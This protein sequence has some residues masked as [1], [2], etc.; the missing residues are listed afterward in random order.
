MSAASIV[1]ATFASV[2]LAEIVGDR[3]LVAIASLASRF[4]ARSV[5]AGVSAAYAL[6]MLVAVIVADA[7]AHIAPPALAAISCVTWLVTAWAVWRR[8]V[9]P[10]RRAASSPHPSLVAFASIAFTEWA[11]PGQLTAA[12]LAAHFGAPFLVWCAATSALLTKAAAALLLGATARQYLNAMWLRGAAAAFCL[13][14]A[15]TSMVAVAQR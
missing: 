15:A 9:E 11:D 1:V 2:L 3:S 4:R 12:V 7:I 13:I 10:S 8:E 6:K 5:F 14:N